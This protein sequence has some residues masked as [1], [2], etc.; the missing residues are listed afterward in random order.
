VIAAQLSR[1]WGLVGFAR[2]R[3][4]SVVTFSHGFIAI[5]FLLQTVLLARILPLADFGR[6]TTLLAIA[7]VLEAAVG[8]RGN[9]TALAAFTQLRPDDIAGREAL[10]RRLL[11]IDLV[12]SLTIYA[13][14]IALAAGTGLFAGEHL[15]WLILL[16]IGSFLT[17][18]WGTTKSYMTVYRGP[19]AFPPVEMTYAA[20]TLAVGVGLSAAIGG[21]GF[22]IGMIAAS[23]ARSLL[24]FRQAGFSPLVM[25]EPPPATSPEVARS[26]WMFGLTG[27]VRSGVL[28]LAGQMDILLLSAM[29]SPAAVGLY[30]AA[31]TLAGVVQRVAL[32][33]WFVLKRHVIVG[34]LDQVDA[35]RSRK[36]IW[37]ASLGVLAGGGIAILPILYFREEIAAFAF[38]P[39]YR[40]AAVA[41]LPL[42]LGAW[43]LY[44]VTG[45][46]MLFGSVTKARATVIGI[47]VLQVAVFAAI[48]L[49][50]G[51]TL[52][53]VALAISL[54]QFLVAAGFWALLVW[55]P[56]LP[57]EEPG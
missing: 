16:M 10:T 47:Y 29:S 2:L 39:E 55:R 42:V 46:S 5:A 49:G 1:L 19:A 6:L 15:D 30:R 54:S 51:V 37:L 14:L 8:A 35:G 4:L 17:F 28:N 31:K 9:E 11:R 26:L 43:I 33:L 22:V 45:W 38:G 36:M 24:A 13:G 20:I 52:G 12:W 56:R 21:L 18:P 7:T 41:I 23:L 57:A 40:A 53:S 44:G 27:T 34:T 3:T 50:M 25:I 48:A 32:P